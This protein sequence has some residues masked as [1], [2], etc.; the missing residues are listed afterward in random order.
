MK[1]N[2]V[3]LL[4]GLA[5]TLPSFAQDK[6]QEIKNQEHYFDI[7]KNVTIFNSIVR[8]LDL[9]YVDTVNVDKTMRV[10][11]DYMLNSLDPY[12]EYY[13]E[14]DMKD[15]T[16]MT[17]GEY[18]G[19]GALIGYKDGKIT[20]MDPYENMPAAKA[21]IKAGDII[22]SIDGVDMTKCD[23]KEGEAYP[24]TLSSFVSSSL[25]GQPST[26]IEIKVERYGEKKPLTFKVTR[27]QITIDPIDY[28]GML[29][30]TIGYISL[31]TFNDKSSK[32]IRK[33][34]DQLKKDGMKSLIFD[35]RNNGGG[36][37]E[38]AV[39]IVNMFVP[40]G[41][42]IVST[43]GKIKQAER[44][45]KTTVEPLDKEIPI[46]VLVNESSASASEIVAGALQDLDRAVL[47]GNRTFGK[48]LVQMTREMP[49][50]GGIK[51]TTAKY[52]TPSGRCVQ[53][54]D[55]SHRKADGTVTRVPDSLTNVFYTELGREVR[56]GGG[57]TPDIMLEEEKTPTITY[58]L[59]NQNIIF[60]WA[61]Q[62]ASK[63]KKIENPKEFTISD[64]DYNNF[65]EFVKSKDFE[66]D[67]MSEKSM[68]QLKEIMEFEG[69]MKTADEEFK[70]L[71]AKLVPN[72]DLDLDL[73][74]AKII[75]LINPEIVKRYYYQKGELMSKLQYD[76]GVKK[77]L[78]VIQDQD[79][80]NKVLS[81]PTEKENKDS[82]VKQKTE[83]TEKN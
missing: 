26:T 63:N 77:A 66:Y 44:V 30:D 6:N 10:G 15:F 17:T 35:L 81:A 80:Y 68:K 39:Q 24:Q 65:K 19:V 74:K 5:L 20:F 38:E 53:A 59:N 58:Y 37:L 70:A 7:N 67:R 43:K 14:D 23:K 69:Y 2:F 64:E 29:N 82:V 45:H 54:L 79:Q 28:Y 11:I 1:H 27:E 32:E 55:Y 40:K 83:T 41:K 34:Y 71:E 36:I 16:F 46:V 56:D 61:T 60:D 62:W 9:L 21:G 57:V 72:L 33:A 3:A 25:K 73:S 18:A 42:T 31:T 78:E 51:I 49:F 75:E 22:L 48:G 13:N 12:N 47:I 50:G 76:N 8:E 4:A 52:Y